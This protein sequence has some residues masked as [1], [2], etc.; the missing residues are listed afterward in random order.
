MGAS[1]RDSVVVVTGASSGV[2]RATAREL[3]R[4]GAR[5]ALLARGEEGLGGARREAEAEG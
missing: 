3:T 4:H 2:G 1:L 5:L